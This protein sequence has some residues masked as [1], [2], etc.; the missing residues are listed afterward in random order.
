MPG[1]RGAVIL[2]GGQSRRMGGQDKSLIHLDG[3]PLID[4]VRA[5][6]APQVD[7][8]AINANGDPA[9]F[10]GM[11][12]E[13]IAD[14]LQGF[15]G[16]LAGVVAA[17]AWA[18]SKGAD[19]V[20]TAPTDCPFLPADLFARLDAAGGLAIARSA[21]GLHPV[22]A[23][24]PVAQEAALRAALARGTRKM[25]DA[26]QSL[27]AAEVMFDATPDPFFNVNT[28]ADLAAARARP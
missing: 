13:V 8:L 7:M 27:G 26:S 10:A 11:G 2:A 14:D 25:R 22:C 24:W 6:L 19:R 5:R 12:V 3:R 16:P 20:L 23:I 1:M 15:P 18:R 17:M 4:H 21:S 28:A 9:R